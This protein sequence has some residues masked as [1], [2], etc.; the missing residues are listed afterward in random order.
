ME[1]EEKEVEETKRVQHLID[2][3]NNRQFRY[4]KVRRLT[5]RADLVTG[6]P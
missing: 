2:E 4:I 3:L 5:E 6:R 1:N